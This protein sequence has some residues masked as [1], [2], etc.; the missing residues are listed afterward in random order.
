MKSH[1]ILAAAA[2]LALAATPAAIAKKPED[3]GSKGKA[4]AEL[5]GQNGKGKGKA[6]AKNIVVKGVVTAASTD[7]SS[8]TIDV[9]KA[10]KHGAFLRDAESPLA[11]SA[12]KV[13]VLDANGDGPTVADLQAGDK[14]VV[15]IRL[16]KDADL[17]GVLAA[18][19]IIDQTNPPADEDEVEDDSE[20]AAPVVT[21]P[22]PVAPATT[23]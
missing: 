5:K 7:G 16:A 20:E 9:T 18:R 17:S 12:A 21:E 14:V 6:K 15:Q 13:V 10:N 4:K 19:K 1:R 22:A 8:V 23:V 3:P 2:T 11:F